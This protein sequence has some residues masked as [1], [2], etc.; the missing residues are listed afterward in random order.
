M[1]HINDGAYNTHLEYI[2]VLYSHFILLSVHVVYLFSVHFVYFMISTCCLFYYPY[3]FYCILLSGPFDLVIT[4]SCFRFCLALCDGELLPCLAGVLTCWV[5]KNRMTFYI[6]LPN[7]QQSLEFVN[8][9]VLFVDYL[10]N[11]KFAQS[12]RAPSKFLKCCCKI[13]NSQS[14]GRNFGIS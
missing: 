2:L 12:S 5:N 13:R 14:S 4:P 3:M 7:S 9:L 1:V 6:S 11:K 10:D 8:Y